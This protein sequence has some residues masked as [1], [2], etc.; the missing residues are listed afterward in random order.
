MKI[1]LDEKTID[2]IVEYIKNNPSKVRE[3]LKV[4]G[5]EAISLLMER[6]MLDKGAELYKKLQQSIN[7]IY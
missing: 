7:Y 3:V 2:N 6:Q 5:D 1:E 4:L